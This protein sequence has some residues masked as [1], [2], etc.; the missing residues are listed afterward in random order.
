MG[1]FTPD[2]MWSA[3]LR[4][5]LGSYGTPGGTQTP[6]LPGRSRMLYS[7]SYWRIFYAFFSFLCLRSSFLTILPF[8]LPVR[9]CN[10]AIRFSLF[11]TSLPSFITLSTFDSFKSK[12]HIFKVQLTVGCPFE[13]NN[14]CCVSLWCPLRDLNPRHPD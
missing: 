2:L 14:C 6:D 7:L 9:P 13:R 10:R 4:G 5:V 8:S 11:S 1:V 3:L 12:T